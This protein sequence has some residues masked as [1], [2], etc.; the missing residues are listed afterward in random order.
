[1]RPIP[2]ICV[3]GSANVDLTFRTPRFPR[4]G[5]TLTGHSFHLGMGG[6]GANQA[7]AA[8]RLGAR[9]S[10]VARVGNDTFG[11][12]AIR[13]YQ[14][15]GIDTT[16]VRT[17]EHCPT[18]TAAI[19]V[20]D[21]AENCII[22]VPGANAGLSPDDV[23][24]ASPAIQNADVLLC[25]LETPLDATLEAF[26]LARAAGVRT[27]LTPAPATELSDEL[28]RLSDLCVPNKTE[29]ELLVGRKIECRDDAESAARL[30]R[31]RGVGTISTV[32]DS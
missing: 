26:R 9:V 31:E 8:A 17:D 4:P 15:E 20:V 29:M 10:F 32:P 13:C 18:G 1:M 2:R 6:K 22:V 30:L 24:E 16:F 14:N 7:V 27:M 5:E 3:V 25:Q 19:V 23:R 11:Q 12:E 28:L 21:N